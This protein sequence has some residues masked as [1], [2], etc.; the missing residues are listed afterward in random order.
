MRFAVRS[1]RTAS[2]G[3]A[4]SLGAFSL[5]AQQGP[6]AVTAPDQ[7]AATPQL[8]L[9]PEKQLKSFEPCGR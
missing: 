1:T 3:L 9:S 2:I 6:T 8:K 4:L 5:L 7:V